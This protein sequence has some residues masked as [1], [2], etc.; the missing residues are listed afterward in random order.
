MSY[1]Q[2]L[3]SSLGDIGAESGT[4]LGGR[5]SELQEQAGL[6]KSVQQLSSSATREQQEATDKMDFN[7]AGAGISSLG[8]RGLKLAR[9]GGNVAGFNVEGMRPA[10]VR[11]ATQDL[12]DARETIGDLA[13]KETLGLGESDLRTGINKNI[14]VRAGDTAPADLLDNSPTS[15]TL[16]QLDNQ[17]VSNFQ[18]SNNSRGM[19]L[20]ESDRNDVATRVQTDPNYTPNPSTNAESVQN[21][22]VK[23]Q[24]IG[25]VEA[26]TGTTETGT[27]SET[28]F[29]TGGTTLGS[30]ESTGLSLAD[31]ATQ[32]AAESTATE[33]MGIL[34]DGGATMLDVGL[35]AVPVIGEVASFGAMIGEGV[36]GAVNSAKEQTKQLTSIDQQEA[37]QITTEKFGMNRPD[38]GSMALP[39]FDVSKNPV[40]LTE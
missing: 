40:A 14:R 24:H 20:N 22:F 5:L 33:S 23:Q 7:L 27:T 38:F 16:G 11:I 36:A 25:D 1:Y 28:S 39:S 6:E 18:Q 26:G 17:K 34:A 4:S 30:T 8:G 9:G 10:R 12:A 3:Q 15:S 2:R 21:E 19:A 13:T 29:G 37:G 35:D 32:K 31:V